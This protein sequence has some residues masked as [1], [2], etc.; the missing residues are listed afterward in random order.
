MEGWVSLLA[1]SANFIIQPCN[2]VTVKPRGVAVAIGQKFP[3]ARVYSHRRAIPQRDLALKDDRALPG[4]VVI[5]TSKTGP[6]V[7]TIFNQFLP[8][9]IDSSEFQTY[10]SWL[11]SAETE[12]QRIVWF[13]SALEQIGEYLQREYRGLP[14]TIAVPTEIGYQNWEW[15]R[16]ALEIF[17]QMRAQIVK[18]VFY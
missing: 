16:Q 8:G 9:A 6:G 2:A 5:C 14:F 3:H 12:Q 18:L 11:K 15:Y 13:V 17:Q 10:A 7:I 4:S 1:T